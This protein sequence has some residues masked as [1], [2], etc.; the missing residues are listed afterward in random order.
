MTVQEGRTESTALGVDIA[1]LNAQLEFET[2]LHQVWC[3]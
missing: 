1:R 2:L 3:S